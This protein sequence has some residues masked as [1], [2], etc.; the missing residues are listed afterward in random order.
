MVHASLLTADN[1]DE[2]IVPVKCTLLELHKRL[3]HLMYDSVEKMADSEDPGIE[4]TDRSRPSCLTCAQ[5]KQSKN[6]QAK[7]DSGLHSPIDRIGGVICSDLK[8]PMTP[9]DRCGN[10]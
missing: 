6:A 9:A 5:G 2:N 10:R 7:K 1:D 4:L 8:G 3:G